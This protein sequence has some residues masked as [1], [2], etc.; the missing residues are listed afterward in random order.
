MMVVI[1]IHIY[2]QKYF[3]LQDVYIYKKSKKNQSFSRK[4][5]IFFKPEY[6]EL[7]WSIKM[8]SFIGGK[9]Q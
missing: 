6:R 5:Y 1:F 2:A 3:F 7:S 9:I 4:E 8:E